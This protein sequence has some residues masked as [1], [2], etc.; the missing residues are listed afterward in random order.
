MYSQPITNNKVWALWI[1]WTYSVG[2]IV[3]VIFL[4]LFISKYW[5]PIVALACE[6]LLTMVVRY[7]REY[8]SSHCLLIPHLCSRILFWSAIIMVIINIIYLKFI[9]A[10]MVESG[11]VN[12]DI[13]YIT[14]LITAPV[15]LVFTT[16]ALI[17]RRHIS[18]C[19]DCRM[20]NGDD[21]ERG[22]IGKLYSQDS[23]YQITLLFW[24]ALLHS[25]ASTLYYFIFYINVNINAPDRFYFVWIPVIFWI[26]SIIYLGFRYVG[27]S[28]YYMQNEL[29]DY[30]QRHRSVML[31]YI[32][33]CGD[34]IYLQSSE[35]VD[36][37]LR[38]DTPAKINLPYRQ[39]I[40]NF[41]AANFYANILK[42]GGNDH[43]LRYLYT[44]EH[45]N[46]DSK[47]HHYLSI[48]PSKE[49]VSAL[50]PSGEWFSM[51]QLEQLL[52]SQKLS[53]FLAAEIMRIYRIAMACKTYHR[54]GTR[55]YKIKNYRP[56]FRLSDIQKL[57]IDFNDSI[58]LF[59][60]KNNEDQPFFHL[61]RFWR[62]H[63]CDSQD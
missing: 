13:P 20:R 63:F 36:G 35:A 14:S 42:H 8:S 31:R 11:E 50:V 47:I 53:S 17:R 32:I 40:S 25:I 12:P 60:E 51:T 29:G 41:D 55:I 38:Y 22:F 21:S 30:S 3:L 24:F 18:F 23:R 46:D 7:H 9:P 61:R 62:R 26:L 6:V 59:I 44:T 15:T 5:L 4:S 34:F 27:L 52:N 16:W 48:A 56:T 39:S 58:W 57:D 33:V 54:D 19:H 28:T 2:A 10:E 37:S 49:A 43:S 1:S 45:Y